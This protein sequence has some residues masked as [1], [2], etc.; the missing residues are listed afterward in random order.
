MTSYMSPHSV[1]RPDRSVS[2]TEKCLTHEI[3]E[4]IQRYPGESLA[5]TGFV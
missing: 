3:D 4:V 1:G 5:N 2:K